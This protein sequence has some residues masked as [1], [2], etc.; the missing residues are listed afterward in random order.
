[1]YEYE[2]HKIREAELLRRAAD[3]RLARTAIR[4]R[5]HAAAV[6]STRSRAGGGSGAG[7][8]DAQEGPGHW[9]RWRGGRGSAPHRYGRAA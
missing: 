3:Y 9:W 1:V 8:G 4:A 5:R 7:D 6:A 2:L